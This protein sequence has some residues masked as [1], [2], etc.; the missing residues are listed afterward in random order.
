MKPITLTMEAFGSYGQK[1]VIDFTKPTQNLFLIT[2]DT[3]AG[4]TTIFDAIVFALFGEGSSNNN[5]KRGAEL[6][7]QFAELTTEPYVELKFAEQ[8]AG[9]EQI[10]TVHRV[11]QHLQKRKRGQG[12]P[13]M[14]AGA[15]ELTLPDDTPFLGSKAEIENK[16]GEIVGLTKSQFMQVGMIAQGEFMDILRQDSDKKREIFRKIFHTGLYQRLVD[17]LSHRMREKG[18]D[19]A[20]FRT[21][22]QTL[23]SN[24]QVPAD[25]ER[26]MQMQQAK[27]A[28]VKAKTLSITAMEN[29]LAELKL[30]LEDFAIKQKL[31]EADYQAAHQA[32]DKAQSD[33][34]QAK[35]LQMAF[36]RLAKAEQEVAA[37]QQGFAAIK[38]L[39]SQMME[40]PTGN[41]NIDL[42]QVQRQCAQTVSQ[43]QRALQSFAQIEQAQRDYQAKQRQLTV[44]QQKQEQT[45]RALADFA[46]QVELWRQQ[47]EQFTDLPVREQKQ[48]QAQ[49]RA[50]ELT[51]ALQKISAQG[52]EEKQQKRKQEEAQ[53]EYLQV[54]KAYQEERADYESKQQAF[55]NAQAG[56]LA[57]TLVPGQPCP[58]C[59][60]SEHPYPCVTKET[61]KALS[62]EALRRFEREVEALNRQ[63]MEKATRAGEAKKSYEEKHQRFVSD[64][65]EFRQNAKNYLP[66]LSEQFSF[67]E[68][69]LQLKQWQQQLSEEQRTLRQAQKQQQDLQAKLQ[70]ADT[71]QKQLQTAA[72]QAKQ[73]VMTVNEQV[74]VAEA[75]IALW[76]QDTTYPNKEAAMMAERQAENLQKKIAAYEQNKAQA[77]GAQKLAAEAVADKEPPELENLQQQF[78][79]AEAKE[80]ECQKKAENLRHIRATNQAVLDKVEPALAKREKVLAEYTRL[81]N[82]Y[83][84]LSGNES[85]GRMDIE[86]Y[87][88]RNYLRQ[89]LVAAN[90]RFQ[91][92]SAGQFVLRMI[93]AKKAGS[94]NK[95]HGLDL[96]VYSTVTG[97]EREARTL[98]GGESFMAALSLALGLADQIQCNAATINLDVMF[99]DEGFGSLDEHAREQAV[100]VLKRMAGGSKLIGLISH[101]TELKQE[102]DSQ[103]LVTKDETG[104]HAVW[105]IS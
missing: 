29:F 48:Q 74:K 83:K 93:D 87:V 51:L 3:G 53:L 99:I 95:N 104:S 8:I 75:Q 44:V 101:V 37:C 41:D 38:A 30:L 6:Q 52:R 56:I 15:V 98:S 45:Q 69:A 63:Q 92:M 64:L 55:L 88:Q 70:N 103:L 60:S 62:R 84:L 91:E 50:Q 59:G 42:Q 10:F 19:L 46:K 32:R 12:D 40:L 79:E 23:V 80:Q 100:R 96:M 65:A 82:L 24:V 36:A 28:V 13:V 11:P 49:E 89:I 73:L 27:D 78:A 81:A 1:T 9:Q 22:C 76:Q 20:Q 97:K 34:Q 94:G 35:N 39:L 5:K 31:A 26:Q 58:V 68:I 72:E 16:I 86:T 85:G 14:K 21:V 54:Q 67:P 77:A 4:K 71:R 90:R 61:V 25:Y 102:I 105:Q 57:Q 17:E 18:K 47:A 7:S 43:A 2:G 33:W 66:N